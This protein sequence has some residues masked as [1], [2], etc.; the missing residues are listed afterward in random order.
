M[1]RLEQAASAGLL[2]ESLAQEA[3]FGM[4]DSSGLQSAA[5]RFR[6]RSDAGWSWRRSVLVPIARARFQRRARHSGR[7]DACKVTTPTHGD[8]LE[9]PRSR[10]PWPP[11]AGTNPARGTVR[12]MLRRLYASTAACSIALIAMPSPATRFAARR[13]GH[14]APPPQQPTIPT[15]SVANDEGRTLLRKALVIKLSEDLQTRSGLGLDPIE[16][17]LVR[18]SWTLPAAGSSVRFADGAVRSW[19]EASAD[20]RGWFELDALEGGYA[21][22]VETS[23]RARVALLEAMGDD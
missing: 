14:D 21:L 22:F 6:R 7:D 3:S 16:A 5:S 4:R 1:S 12:V 18:G 23:D 10:H 8:R 2:L 15:E 17:R 19:R 13:V 11:L 20:P 9:A